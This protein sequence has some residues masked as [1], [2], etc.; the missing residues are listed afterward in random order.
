LAA[1]EQ[2]IRREAERMER[3]RMADEVDAFI[4]ALYRDLIA[5]ADCV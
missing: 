3:E 2:C 1:Q 5:P 4:A